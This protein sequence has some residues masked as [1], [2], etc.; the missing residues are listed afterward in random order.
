MSC[1]VIIVM[2]PKR[3]YSLTI[4]KETS[5]LISLINEKD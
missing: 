1:M 5:S 4:V 2:E 3:N